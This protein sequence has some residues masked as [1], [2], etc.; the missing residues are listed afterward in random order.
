MLYLKEA[1]MEDAAKEYAFVSEL[2]MLW[3]FMRRTA[4]ANAGG[5]ASSRDKKVNPSVVPIPSH[6]R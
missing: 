1:N 2:P 3:P 4:M 6:T 5:M